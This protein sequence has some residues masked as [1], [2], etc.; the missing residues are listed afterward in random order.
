MEQKDFLGISKLQQNIKTDAGNKLDFAGVFSFKF[1]SSTPNKFYVKYAA[2][3]SYQAVNLSKK[4]SP[5]LFNLDF[6]PL[7]YS[8]PSKK[9]LDNIKTLLPFIPP[10]HHSHFDLLVPD[11]NANDEGAEL[12]Q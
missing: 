7:K 3:D 10:I 4:G 2:N 11:T 6:I 8:A 5:A 12:L 9:K 1:D